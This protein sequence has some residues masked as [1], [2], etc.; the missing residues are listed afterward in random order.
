[1][2]E[3][4]LLVALVILVV[5]VWKPFKRNVLGALD[6]RAERIRAELD[7]AQRLQEE[8]KVMLAKYQR[9]L[10]EGEK[11]AADIVAQ[12]EAERARL[13]QKMRADF[14][15][16]VKRRTEQAVERIAQEEQKALAE[17]RARAADLAVRTA[18][19][20]LTERLGERE[21][22]AMVRGAIEDVSRK[23]A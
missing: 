2:L 20:L 23:L 5:A 8:A 13:E 6:S 15:A 12:A 9:Q 7:E 21:A 17:V 1:M 14:D 4:I 11:L 22:Q 10:H 3:L 18:R 19:R 16:A